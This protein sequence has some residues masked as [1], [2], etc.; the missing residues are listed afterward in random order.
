VKV[1]RTRSAIVHRIADCDNCNWRD[2]GY[3]TA[4]RYARRHSEKTGHTTNVENGNYYRYKP[5]DG[6][7]LVDKNQLSLV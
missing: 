4:S 3:K 1:I 2:E 5:K 6:E 7:T